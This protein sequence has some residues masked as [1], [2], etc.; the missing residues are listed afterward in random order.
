M[1][2][3]LH[4]LCLLSFSHINFLESESG[5]CLY[6]YTFLLLLMLDS[7]LHDIYTYVCRIWYHCG[8][9]IF[10]LRNFVTRGKYE[11]ILHRIR[12]INYHTETSVKDIY[13]YWYLFTS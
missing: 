4:F 5:Y 11:V 10:V 9:V 13:F 8:G 12:I 7:T 2:L 6:S 3:T 1:R